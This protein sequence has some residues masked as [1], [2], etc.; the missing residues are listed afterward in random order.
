MNA[1]ERLIESTQ[2]LLWERGYVATSPKAIQ[3]RAGVGQG[4]MYHHFEGKPEL[5]VAAVRRS[6]DELRTDVGAILDGPGGALERIGA[7]LVRERDVLR[8]CRI[9]GLTQDPEII[10][11]QELRQPLEDTFTWLRTRLRDLIAEGQEGGEL[12]QSVAPE[13]LASMICAV[14]QGGYVLAR[15]GQSPEPFREAV[16]GARGLLTMISRPARADARQ[17]EARG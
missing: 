12:R 10:A 13:Q 16:A 3:R 14:V 8:G 15:A 6:A 11:N 7:Y 5:A 2:E 9:G 4:S 1:Q 17:E